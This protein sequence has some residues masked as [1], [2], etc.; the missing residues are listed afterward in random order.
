MK[1]LFKSGFLALSILFFTSA[2]NSKTNSEGTSD[3]LTTNS[4]GI[5]TLRADTA[6]D[7]DASGIGAGNRSGGG[8]RSGTRSDTALDGKS[9]G[10]GAGNRTGKR[11]DTTRH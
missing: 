5:D 1:N 6:L 8:A 3:S 4:G 9:G 11:S 7:G 10:I 2:C